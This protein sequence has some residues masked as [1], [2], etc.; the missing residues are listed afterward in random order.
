MTESTD[1]APPALTDPAPA[2]PEAASAAELDEA[3]AARR[4]AD[5]VAQVE[6]DQRAYSA[7][8]ETGWS[9]S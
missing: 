9:S 1:A 6:A 7:S 3:A 4:W 8:D 2:L 5:L